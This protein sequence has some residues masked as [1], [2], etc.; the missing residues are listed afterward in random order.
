MTAFGT[1]TVAD[2]IATFDGEIA[3]YPADSTIGRAEGNRVG[4]K[5][6]MPGDDYNLTDIEEINIDGKPYNWEE[7]KD[8]DGTYFEWWPLVTE[9]NKEFTATIKWNSASIQEFKIVI[10]SAATLEAAPEE[11]PDS[12][13]T[14][15][16]E[17]V[18]KDGVYSTSFAWGSK[19]GIGSKD[20]KKAGSPGEYNYYSDGAFLRFTVKHN[21]TQK[22]FNEVFITKDDGN[23]TLGGMTL[24]TNN[25]N[26]NDMDGSNRE[27]ADW[28][29]TSKVSYKTNLPGENALFYGVIQNADVGTKTVG[30]IADE[31]RTINMTLEPLT[32]LAVGTYTVEVEVVQQTTEKV[33]DSISYNIVIK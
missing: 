13:L 30:F 1:G 20:V 21:D 6:A 24:Q 26:V 7:I 9:A 5:I 27:L 2:S 25:G 31:N 33:F 11:E 10:D 16:G 3:W 12:Y 18:E 23:N 4:V 32:E 14:K 22:K 8:G 15:S 19:N 17:L 29:D 28:G